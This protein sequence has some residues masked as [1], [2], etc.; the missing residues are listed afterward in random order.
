MAVLTGKI[1]R[2]MVYRSPCG[3][4]CWVGDRIGSSSITMRHFCT[5]HL[6]RLERGK[7]RPARL[8]DEEVSVD[9]LWL[10][11]N[12]L[13]LINTTLVSVVALLFGTHT[14]R[15]SGSGGLALVAHLDSEE[16]QECN[17]GSRYIL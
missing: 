4:T 10:Y 12:L 15:S 13:P 16:D 9:Q 1:A 8:E 5:P 6:W 2:S 3:Y 11:W 7:Y 14:L 17:A